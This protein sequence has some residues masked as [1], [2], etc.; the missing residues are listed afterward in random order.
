MPYSTS[1]LALLVACVALPAA[2]ASQTAAIPDVT[3]VDVRE[4]ITRPAM[5]VVISGDRIAAVGPSGSVAV[6]AQARVVDGT[7]RFLIPGLWDMH[8]HTGNDRNTREI[9]YPLLVAHGVTGIREMH[10]DC[11]EC[12]NRSIEHV[13]A[14]RRAVAAGELLGPRVVASSVFAGSHG[15]AARRSTEGSSP[16][17]PATEA[18][19]RAFVRL[20]KER[21]VD[22]IKV[23]DMLPRDAYFA[24]VDE[25]KRLGLPFAGH[26]PVAVRASEA[27]DAGQASIE[28]LGM[29]N[30][31]EECSS[32]ED[33]LRA[34]VI[35]ELYD[36]EMGSRHT[37][38]GPVILPLILEMVGTHDEEKCAALAARFVRNGTWI[39]PTLMVARLPSELGA[40]W[41]EDRYA[42]FL[43]PEERRFFES[44]EEA[45]ARDLGDPEERAPVSRWVRQT[46]RFMHRAGVRMLAGSDAGDPGVFWGISLHQE[47]EL[48][49]DAGLTEAEALRVATLGPAE[50]LG[51]TDSLGTVEAGKLADL[52]LLDANP[53]EDISH[54]QRI[55]GVVLNGRYL[56][57]QELDVLLAQAEAVADASREP[58]GASQAQPSGDDLEAAVRAE[59]EEQHRREQKAFVEG[60]CETVVSFYSDEATI[61]RGGRRVDDLSEALEFCRKLPRPFTRE[62]EPPEISDR[63]YVLSGNAAHFVRTIDFAPVAEESP[64]FKREVVTKVWLK[65]NDGWKIVHFHSSTH[66]VSND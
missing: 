23:Y 53:L 5:T 32:R 54:T 21:G 2:V 31:L 48:L 3:I 28:H 27:S 24:L 15:Q 51:A 64:A 56:D 25:A 38:N 45:Y 49:V 11:F 34:R 19:A 37:S 42:R 47:L 17:A 57:L 44:A 61:Y 63:F 35:A 12:P 43:I 30:V 36:A 59:V 6:P 4:G 7:G 9:V 41:R 1:V 14:Q 26:V 66:T 20:A 22:F 60:D 62:G 10:A 52:V 18:D 13:N 46:T 16:Q 65:T 50:F 40:G 39:V 8:V 33:E 29:G 58:S 55:A